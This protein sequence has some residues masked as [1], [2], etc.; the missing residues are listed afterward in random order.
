MGIKHVVLFSSLSPAEQQAR[1]WHIGPC[2]TRSH[3]LLPQ[4][5]SCATGKHPA[6]LQQRAKP[7]QGE[8]S[9]LHKEQTKF[10]NAEY[11][12][13]PAYGTQG[14]GRA[15]HCSLIPFRGK[16]CEFRDPFSPFSTATST[17]L[18]H[19][20]QLRLHRSA[21]TRNAPSLCTRQAGGMLCSCP[22]AAPS[23]WQ[24][25]VPQPPL[26]CCHTAAFR[27]G[28]RDFC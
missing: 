1:P 17:R 8:T 23:H 11:N 4:S 7:P 24:G 20:K 10:S 19:T 22:D 21:K 9:D 18:P 16:S 3:L 27:A 12:D 15:C 2:G 28:L 26:G 5:R 6:P 25:H 14:G 13:T